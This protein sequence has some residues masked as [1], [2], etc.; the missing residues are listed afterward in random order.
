MKLYTCPK[1]CPCGF[2]G[3]MLSRLQT[4]GFEPNII[5]DDPEDV[6]FEYSL[7]EDWTITDECE[8]NLWLFSGILECLL[9]PCIICFH[10][11][12]Q[13][14]TYRNCEC[15]NQL[16]VCE[17][18][19]DA[20]RLPLAYCSLCKTHTQDKLNQNNWKSKSIEEIIPE[21]LAGH[22]S[23]MNLAHLKKN[24]ESVCGKVNKPE[25]INVLRHLVSC[26]KIKRKNHN[27]YGV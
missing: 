26:G 23:G 2:F 1:D 18:C 25:L 16:I 3:E 17:N 9:N 24:L 22:E 8:F 14:P 6:H 19:Y 7:P 13:N 21:M 27:R 20:G 4:K 10:R 15:G 5:D 12:Y 11:A